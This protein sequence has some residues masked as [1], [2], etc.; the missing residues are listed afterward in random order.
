MDKRQA[1]QIAIETIVTLI[2]L[3]IDT[4]SKLTATPAGKVLY[5][6]DSQAKIHDQMRQIADQL[7]VK[8][9]RYSDR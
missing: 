7:K 9:G 2:E 5:D 1:R 6:R 4:S 8:L 3:D